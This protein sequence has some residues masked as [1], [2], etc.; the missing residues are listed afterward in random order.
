MTAVADGQR[1]GGEGRTSLA[2]HQLE[3][4]EARPHGTREKATDL[5]AVDP[6]PRCELFL[7]DAV[8]LQMA[9]NETGDLVLHARRTRFRVRVVRPRPGVEPVVTEVNVV[10]C[11]VRRRVAK[12]HSRAD[13]VSWRERKLLLVAAFTI[14][15]CTA[16]EHCMHNADSVFETYTPHIPTDIWNELKPFVV[17]TV[18]AHYSDGRT[19]DDVHHGLMTLTGFADWVYTLGLGALGADILRGD[20]IDAY[21]TYRKTEVA[22]FLAERERKRL[23]IIAGLR[24]GPEARPD[25][26]SSTPQTPHSE[27]EQGEIRRWTEW[28]ARAE[29]RQD[30][31]AIAALGLGCGLTALEMMRARVGDVRMLDDAFLGVEVNGRVVP[32]L[33]A[34]HDELATV[35]PGLSEDFLIGRGTTVRD[36]AGLQDIITSL[37]GLRPSAQRMRATWMLAHVDAGTPLPDFLDAAG[38]KSPDVLR[39]LLKFAARLP[40]S[41][42]TTRLRLSTE[43]AR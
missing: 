6:D 16:H 11:V 38:L 29:R 24:S 33:D 18:R 5:W 19:R 34:W 10:R 28:Q 27:A 43:V 31:T 13:S 22:G 1:Y 17:E 35:L 42:R 39:R 2:E 12:I 8:E 40:E 41:A 7:R 15:R 36:S 20:V 26:T 9:A 30:A 25:S 32:V 37:P 14:Q 21:T 3:V 23:R 4:D